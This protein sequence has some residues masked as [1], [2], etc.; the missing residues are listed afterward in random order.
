M[1]LF[2]HFFIFCSMLACHASE[3]RLV[4]KLCAHIVSTNIMSTADEPASNGLM[5]LEILCT[6]IDLDSMAAGQPNLIDTIASSSA[7]IYL[8]FA[9]LSGSFPHDLR[10][11]KLLQHAEPAHRHL[12]MLKFRARAI[13]PMVSEVN[14]P[15]WCIMWL[16]LSFQIC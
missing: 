16:A 5:I 7:D 10:D 9:V 11:S 12:D 8:V 13:S 6:R 14:S 3:S 2:T 1:S 15:T 4:A